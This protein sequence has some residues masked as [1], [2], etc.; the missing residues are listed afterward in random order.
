[1]HKPF[2]FAPLCP[3]LFNVINDLPFLTK[4]YEPDTEDTQVMGN[5]LMAHGDG[6]KDVSFSVLD[7]DAIV[8][9]AKDKG[10]KIDKDIWEET[11]QFGK[12]NY[13]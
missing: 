3:P 13:C 9:R 5:H 6:V 4:S 7:L 1:M 11:D 12:V 10:C 8:Q 2:Q